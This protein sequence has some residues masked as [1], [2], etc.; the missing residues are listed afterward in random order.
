MKAK[1][2]K[3]GSFSFNGVDI[4]QLIVDQIVDNNEKAIA[5]I[6]AGWAEVLEMRKCKK[7]E[8]SEK[9]VAEKEVKKSNP[10]K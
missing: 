2:T 1:V 9:S 3:K 8:E 7:H 10:K 4:E 5:L 6:E